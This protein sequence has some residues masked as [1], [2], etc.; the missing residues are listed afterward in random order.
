M[1][2][3]I[4]LL[5]ALFALVATDAFAGVPV[6]L[7]DQ[8]LDE[9]GRVTLGDLFENAGRAS[10][11]LLA[12]GP[13]PGANVV[14]D[15]ARVQQ[16]ARVN[17]LDWPNSRGFRR[18]VVKNGAAA[19]GPDGAGGTA[20]QGRTTEILTYTRSLAAGEIVQ[21]EDVAW[22]KVQSHLVPGDAP[23]DAETV[24][25]QSVRRAM[26]TGSPV[27]Q[28]DLSR[29]IVVKTNDLITVTY[30]LDGV[31]LSLQGK[32]LQGGAA[33]DSISVLNPQSKKTIVAVVSGP[34]QAVVGPEAEGLRSSNR[35]ASIR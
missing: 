31:S 19:S 11:V 28:R 20:A 15:A 6:Q 5:A 18:L 1:N 9:D 7:K 35:S 12:A 16:I 23:Q 22:T 2:R 14:L 8:L 17:G 13:G 33:G 4:A 24:I 10:N 3:L 25:G 32:A 27:A 26:R 21:P 30:N 34:G 29:P